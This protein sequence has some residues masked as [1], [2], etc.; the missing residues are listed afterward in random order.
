MARKERGK[1]V[2][3]VELAVIFGVSLP[4]IDAWVRGGMPCVVEG[5][6]GVE[7]QFNTRDAINWHVAQK[8]APKGAVGNGTETL[9]EAKRRREI[10]NADLAEIDLAER[11]GRV[12]PIEHVAKQVGRLL[13]SVR[14]RL[15]AIPTKVAP[16]A[17]TAGSAEEIRS[18]IEDSIREA[19]TEIVS[20]AAAYMEAEGESDDDA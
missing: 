19:M 11:R 16:V 5:G 17:Q 1:I 15:L 7:Y 3:R 8:A 20:A 13:S 12:V 9:E 18:M 14:A 6:R 10:T 4:T 2:N